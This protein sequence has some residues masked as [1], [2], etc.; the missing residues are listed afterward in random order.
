MLE[1]EG[2]VMAT[3]EVT[4]TQ[5]AVEDFRS[6]LLTVLEE[7]FENVHGYMLDKGTSL[8]ETLASVSAE[9][10]SKPISSQCAPLSAQ[11]NHTRFYIDALFQG[12]ASGWEQKFDWAGS[13]QVG[14]VT[15]EEWQDLI[16]RLRAAYVQVQ[17]FAKSFDDWNADFIG[18]AFALVG[19]C[20]YHLGEIRQGLGVLRG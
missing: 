19:H 10:A 11:V 6:G 17:E 3:E 20:A 4:T 7:I 16:A 1:Q 8:F 2:R 14:E 5:I 18:G 12:L 15:E 9:E 13:W